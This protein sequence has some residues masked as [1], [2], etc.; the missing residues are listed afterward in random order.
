MK[1]DTIYQKNKNVW[2]KQPNTLLQKIYT[3]VDGTAEFLDLGCGQGRDSLFMLQKGFSVTAVDNSKEGIKKIRED[4]KNN[5]LQADKIS[6]FCEDIK[7]F[8]IK[9][10]KFSIINV[11]NS[12]QFLSKTDALSVIDKIKDGLLSGGYIIISGFINSNNQLQNNN[13]DRGYFEVGELKNLFSNFQIIIYEEKMINDLG[14]PGCLES[15]QHYVV[16]MVARYNGVR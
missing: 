14:H 4:I 9:K 6:L 3:K 5:S 13:Q 8:K 11:F 15:H 10:N 1:Y 16:K 7:D 2:G 12:L